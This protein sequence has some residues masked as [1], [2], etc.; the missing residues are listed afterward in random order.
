VN[1]P[2][3]DEVTNPKLQPALDPAVKLDFE[4]P[5]AENIDVTHM[6]PIPIIGVQAR[7]A[8]RDDIKHQRAPFTQYDIIRSMINSLTAEQ[9]KFF[10]A[11]Y[12]LQTFINGEKVYKI[13]TQMIDGMING[14]SNDDD[15]IMI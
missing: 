13:G 2:L 12:I 11:R 6:G 14:K 9:L 5:K 10:A 4:L 1:T 15:D 3:E 7:P 8:T